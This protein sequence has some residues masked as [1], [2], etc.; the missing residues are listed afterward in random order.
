MGKIAYKAL[1]SIYDITP[2]EVIFEAVG[3]PIKLPNNKTTLFAV[4]YCLPLEQR[5]RPLK[6][7]ISDW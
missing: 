5:T 2:K 6:Q 3:K 4:Q 1:C 7:Q